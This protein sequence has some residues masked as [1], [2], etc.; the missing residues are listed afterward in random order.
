MHKIPWNNN[1]KR[2]AC[3][4]PS[5]SLL[6]HK[7]TELTLLW[8]LFFQFPER[9]TSCNGSLKVLIML[10]I[11]VKMILSIRS[12][13]LWHWALCWPNLFS[14]LFFLFTSFSCSSSWI[15]FSLSFQFS[16]QTTFFFKHRPTKVMTRTTKSNKKRCLESPVYFSATLLLTTSQ[17]FS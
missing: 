2:P 1:E 5:R 11:A 15:L 8:L 14:V 16:S 10:W 12:E 4:A 13:N 7:E 17:Y 3:S 9:K 6:V